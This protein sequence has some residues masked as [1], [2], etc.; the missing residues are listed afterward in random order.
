MAEKC[1]FCP[2]WHWPLTFDFDLQ[3]CPSEGSTRLLCEFG[4]N[5]FSGSRDILYTNIKPTDWRRQKQNLP[6]FTACGNH[7][8]VSDTKASYTG[9]ICIVVKFDRNRIVYKRRF[10]TQHSDCIGQVYIQDHIFLVK[11]QWIFSSNC[12]KVW[13]YV[14]IVQI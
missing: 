13:F 7:C 3:S 11:N 10:L 6:Q 4:A 12:F 14:S 9:H 2:W 8:P 5:P 1:R